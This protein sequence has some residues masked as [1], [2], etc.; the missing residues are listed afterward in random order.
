VALNFLGFR[1]KTGFR[2]KARGRSKTRNQGLG[3][4]V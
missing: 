1:V 4:R 2:S 3:F